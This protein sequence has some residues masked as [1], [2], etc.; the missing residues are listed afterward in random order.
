M[1]YD[2]TI[3]DLPAQYI[4]MVDLISSTDAWEDGYIWPLRKGDHDNLMRLPYRRPR[5]A[6][7]VIHLC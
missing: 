3:A 5:F 1:L 4:R 2:I 6:A 7:I